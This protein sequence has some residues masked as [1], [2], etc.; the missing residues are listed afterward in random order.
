M[1]CCSIILVAFVT[2]SVAMDSAYVG[3]WRNAAIYSQIDISRTSKRGTAITVTTATS[4]PSCSVIV[5][6][7]MIWGSHGFSLRNFVPE[8]RTLRLLVCISLPADQSSSS[9]SWICFPTL[10]FF[11]EKNVVLSLKLVG[12][13]PILVCVC[14]TL[15]KTVTN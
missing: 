6:V 8:D 10:F 15:S 14:I 2:G 4:L 9:S 3:P 11:S 1:V 12:Y 5:D 7:G 13:H